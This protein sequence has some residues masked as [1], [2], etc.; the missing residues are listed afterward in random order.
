MPTGLL[1]TVLLLQAMELA[2]IDAPLWCATR[3]A[4]SAGPGGP[5][6]PAQAQIWGLGRV[7]ALEYPG[8]WGGLVDLPDV[9]D[10]Y[11]GELLV[12]TLLGGGGEDQVAVRASGL[13]ARRLVRARAEGAAVRAW[14]PRGTVLVTGGTGALGAHVARWLAAKGA[15]RVVL[16][17]RRGR[18]A[19]GA[20]ELEA[21]LRDLGTEVTV[22]ACD[23]ADRTALA[24]LLDRI[25][26][27]TAV[28][29]A[30]GTGAIGPLAEL[31]A[32]QLAAAAAAKVAGATHLD[33]LLGA[34]ELDAFVLMSSVTAVWGGGGQAAYAAANAYLDALAA[35]RRDSGRTATSV[36][37]GPWAG[38]GMS[39]GQEEP[40]RRMGLPALAPGRA[41]AALGQAVDR[42]DTALAVCE[43]D[44]SRFHP[45]FTTFRAARLFAALPEIA[46]VEPAREGPRRGEA[47]DGLLARL[48]AA[49]GGDRA[50]LLRDLV[51]S[52]TSQ[53]LG[54]ATADAVDG[55]RS[56]QE[57]G[58]DSLMSV[59]LRNRL[60]DLTG[61]RLPATLLFDHPTP[62]AITRHLLAELL[63]DHEASAHTAAPAAHAAARDDDPVA[64]VG[65]ACRYPGGVNSPEALWRLLSEGRDAIGPFPTDRGWDT[66]TLFS[67]DPGRAGTCRT[68]EGGFLY[69]AAAFDPEFFGISP[70]E[71]LAMDPQQRLLLETSWEAV[72]R[73]GIAPRALRG[74]RTGV[75]TGI[76]YHDYA[77]RFLVPPE[78]VE[79]YLGN[80]SAASVASGRVAYTLGLEGPA[81]SVDTACSSSLVA[82]HLAATALQRGECSLALAG[83]VAVMSTPGSFVEFSRQGGLAPDGRCKSF[84]A[85]AD[86]TAWG[87]GAGVLL[88]ERLSDARRN[89]HQVLAVI[90]GTAIN[91]DGASNG[92]TAPSGPA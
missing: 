2:E 80:G 57:Q 6:R 53:V 14:R 21:E 74:S 27:L 35:R 8:R 75:F 87:E 85:G 24:A 10:A 46:E 77:S 61:L 37:W 64:I 48:A 5:V 41:L 36:A 49:P 17:S 3:G 60:G 29:H 76:S 88:L 92:L 69:G 40:L 47:A 73:A 89:G 45:G 50:K 38:A 66:A 26:P 20:P 22:A 67:D 1:G 59:E 18:D 7:A 68:R 90:R 34:Q 25:G 4:V 86:G 62:H 30:A 56:F 28:V 51:R 23:V 33:E 81:L 32:D 16:T 78:E 91:Q 11:T 9:L 15:E 82:V 83:G 63:G 39:S 13:F 12:R 52:E 54:H 19:D 71:A 72:E 55:D 79:G 84:S 42:D 31:T 43:V 65:V 44:W 58:F 70:R